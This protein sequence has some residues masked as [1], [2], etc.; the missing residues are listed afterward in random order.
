MRK[1]NTNE[2]NTV[3]GGLRHPADVYLDN[4]IKTK[5]GSR[6]TINLRPRLTSS[7]VEVLKRIPRLPNFGRDDD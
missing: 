3:N 4:R 2:L 5:R 7:L 6:F 1:L